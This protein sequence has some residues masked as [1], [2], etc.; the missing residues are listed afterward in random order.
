VLIAKV[1]GLTGLVVLEVEMLEE[2]AVLTA[3]VK[4]LVV[5]VVMLEVVAVLIAE[6]KAL[7]MLE[8]EMLEDI[9]NF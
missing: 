2:V 9:L 4:G 1:K 8:L 7:I 6:V 3:K 5:E